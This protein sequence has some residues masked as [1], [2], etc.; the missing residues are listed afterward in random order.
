VPFPQHAAEKAVGTAD[1]PVYSLV[2][3]RVS[4][5]SYACQVNPIV[6]NNGENRC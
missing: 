2:P 6:P 4:G 3:W 1:S 5:Y